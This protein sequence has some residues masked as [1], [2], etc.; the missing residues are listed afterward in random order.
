M[1][2]TPNKNQPENIKPKEKT[3]IGAT[4]QK[5]FDQLTEGYTKQIR[6]GKEASPSDFRF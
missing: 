4:G 6:V 2:E 3:Q 5:D 1:K